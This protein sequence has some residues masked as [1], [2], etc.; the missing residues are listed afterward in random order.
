[1]D[2]NI[3]PCFSKNR[4]FPRPSVNDMFIFGIILSFVEDIQSQ[5]KEKKCDYHWFVLRLLNS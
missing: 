5:S 4:P 3:F 2:N 1:M